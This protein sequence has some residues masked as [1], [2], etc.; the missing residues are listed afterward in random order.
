[1]FERTRAARKG[2]D[3]QPGEAV[4]APGPAPS[5]AGAV[6]QFVLAGL[7]VV[8]VVG[9]VG[10][11]VLRALGHR[12]AIRNARQL[13]ALAG[14]GIIEPTLNRRVLAG[15]P[16][17]LARLDRVVQERI[18]DEG[19]VRVKIWSSDGRIVYSDEQQLIGSRYRLGA[20]E[21]ATLRTGAAKAELSDLARPENRFERRLG[22]LYEVYTRIRAP[23]GQP[24]LFETYQPSSALVSSG[25][26]IWLP[27][28]GALLAGL[29][30]LW[31]IQVPLAWRLARRLQRSHAERERLLMVAV[32]SSAE[33]RR[34]I[35]ADLHDGV[36]QDLVGVSYSLSA[37]AD[38]GRP[39]AEVRKTLVEAASATRAA[40]R[41]LRTL[42]LEIH[43][44]NLR[45][46]GLAAALRDLLAP[47][48]AR[49]IDTEL[50]ITDGLE[51]G[52][53][54]ELLV[55]RA[56]GEAIRNVQRHASAT[57]VRVRL[58]TSGRSV[59][60]T[61][62]DDGVGLRSAEREHRRSQGHMG[63]EL[64]EELAARR[65]GTL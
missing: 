6:G 53:D 30:L 5:V 57:A 12:E 7:V 49:G 62:V 1:M 18:L 34:R 4:D 37:T 52:A 64:L 42:L 46:A 19:V 21:L 47:L 38:S 48:S 13:A 25:R 2:K 55:F 15:D 35:A 26:T 23:N 27:F 9:V 16:Q 63:L 50:E 58:D 24:L 31:L 14:Q 32:E 44:P 65:G 36:V 40:I 33:E 11:F 41:Q 61:V 17:A 39:T 20:D 56:A 3:R 60:L 54:T 43:P 8:V 45:S 10:L 28:A 51:V 29:I 22:P 59:R